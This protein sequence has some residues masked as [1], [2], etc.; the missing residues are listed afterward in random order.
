MLQSFIVDFVSVELDGLTLGLNFFQV[1]NKRH[2]LL[3]SRRVGAGSEI[4]S[5]QGAIDGPAD[6]LVA[7]SRRSQPFASSLS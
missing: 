1:L 3:E 7:A 2:D 5:V 6:Q 4:R